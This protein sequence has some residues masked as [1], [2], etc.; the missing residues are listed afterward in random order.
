MNI[1]LSFY[2]DYLNIATG[3]HMRKTNTSRKRFA[4]GSIVKV[5][6]KGHMRKLYRENFIKK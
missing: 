5:R 1:I 6:R 4:Y 2:N 3:T